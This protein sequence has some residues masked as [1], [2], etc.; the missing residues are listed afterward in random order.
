ML[1]M[2]RL[3]IALLLSAPR[4]TLLGP[5]RTLYVYS[6]VMDTKVMEWYVHWAEVTG[7]GDVRY[8]QNTVIENRLLKGEN[9]LSNLRS[10]THYILEWGLMERKP[11]VEKWYEAIAKHDRNI[12]RSQR[13]LTRQT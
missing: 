8:H 4:G 3:A 6:A 11:V 1:V 9:A 12:P 2:K 13:R 5:T 7:S 10:P